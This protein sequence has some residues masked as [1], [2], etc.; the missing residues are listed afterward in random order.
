MTRMDA[1]RWDPKIGIDA[2]AAMDGLSSRQAL[3]GITSGVWGLSLAL[4]GARRREARAATSTD[5]G[6]RHVTHKD[7]A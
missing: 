1:K 7:E 6:P 2:P 4:P 3:T 5:K